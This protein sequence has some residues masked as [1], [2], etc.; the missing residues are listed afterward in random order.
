VMTAVVACLMPEETA[1]ENFYFAAAHLCLWAGRC[2][3]LV[4]LPAYRQA[5]AAFSHYSLCLTSGGGYA[6]P[7]FPPLFFFM[8]EGRLCW[9]GRIVVTC[10]TPSASGSID[11][12]FR[13]RA[14]TTV[15]STA[16]H[17]HRLR[18]AAFT[19]AP[20]LR[21]TLRTTVRTLPARCRL[22]TH[23]SDGV[24]PAC[25]VTV[26][27]W[28]FYC[29]TLHGC[30]HASRFSTYAE[31]YR[32]TGFCACRLPGYTP[33]H[34]PVANFVGL[35]ACFAVQH[36][37]Q[38]QAARTLLLCYAALCCKRHRAHATRRRI[39]GVA[40][41]GVAVNVGLAQRLWI[42]TPN[43]GWRLFGTARLS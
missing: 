20:C 15:P 23:T 5:C 8:Q 37:E 18:L 38:Q 21:R 28:F 9:E 35:A 30:L 17:S 29:F 22:R 41:Y 43:T 42:P 24:I 36:A 16:Q 1:C 40:V 27:P 26:I 3:L 14:N 6:G 34:I 12:V 33:A 25:T 4:T 32:A 39:A 19:T 11:A 10:D 31:R 7:Q 13:L 2:S